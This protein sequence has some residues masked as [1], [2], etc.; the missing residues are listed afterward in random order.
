MHANIL[1]ILRYKFECRLHNRLKKDSP[2]VI[3]NVC[4]CVCSIE[5]EKRCI[6]ESEYSRNLML[7]AQ[8]HIS[9]LK[10]DM[11]HVCMAD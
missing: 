1:H 2:A 10:I 5:N 3:S 4:E 6:N 8:S 11:R 7:I 9:R